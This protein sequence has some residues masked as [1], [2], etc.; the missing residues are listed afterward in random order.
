MPDRASADVL[1]DI[2][3]HPL[4]LRI[5]S[6][7]AGRERT[8]AGLM[9]DLP[10]VAPATL[11]RHLNA[12]AEAGLLRVAS[13]RQARGAVERSYVLDADAGGDRPSDETVQKLFLAF[14][15]SLLLDMQRHLRGSSRDPAAPLGFRKAVLHATDEQLAA[16]AAG[17][18]ALVEPLL[19]PR[20][21]PGVHRVVLAT[22]LIPDAEES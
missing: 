10:D 7:L 20:R 14:T 1:A 13:E 21:G 4:R 15:G 9:E 11:Y 17:L 22:V 3:L 16:L 12:L 19:A 5:L 8:A 18:H 6:A 2:A